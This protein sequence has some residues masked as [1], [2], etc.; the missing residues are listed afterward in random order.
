VAAGETKLIARFVVVGAFSWGIIYKS[1]PFSS[2]LIELMSE[3]T[4]KPESYNHTASIH[5]QAVIKS[6]SNIHSKT[7][8]FAVFDNQI[9]QSTYKYTQMHGD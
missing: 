1:P 5:A 9:A 8:S 4:S 2:R 3:T 7:G 6:R